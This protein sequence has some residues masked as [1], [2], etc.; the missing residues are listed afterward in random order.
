MR[1]YRIN[2]V[3]A[4]QHALPFGRPLPVATQSRRCN[5]DAMESTERGRK[6]LLEGRGALG[7]KDFCLSTG[8]EEAVVE[9]L[10]RSGRLQ[11]AL[12]SQED[13][14][15]SI[16]DDALP[17]RDELVAMG[18]P[19]RDDYDPDH[20]RYGGIEC[21][22]HGWTPSVLHIRYDEASRRE[23]PDRIVCWDCS[24]AGVPLDSGNSSPI[25]QERVRRWLDQ[26]QEPDVRE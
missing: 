26:H 25:P 24:R 19:V 11:G 9:E 13:R 21:R 14:P 10:M 6:P 8:L 2:E 3:A 15:H 16:F 1:C 18:L 5:D 4:S 12:F 7:F 22:T 20:P 17:S 23:L